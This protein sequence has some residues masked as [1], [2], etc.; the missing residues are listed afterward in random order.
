M[1]PSLDP[2]R[3]RLLLQQAC[4]NFIAGMVIPANMGVQCE[5]LRKSSEAN[6]L[7]FD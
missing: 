4:G 3:Q 6:F 2:A 5:W 7:K 1:F